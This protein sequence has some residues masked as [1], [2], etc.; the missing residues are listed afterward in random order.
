MH[1][2]PEMMSFVIAMIGYLDLKWIIYEI[3]MSSDIFRHK[4]CIL[5]WNKT[6]LSK[7]NLTQG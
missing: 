4:E 3:L 6:H 7:Q 2:T 1:D 5:T